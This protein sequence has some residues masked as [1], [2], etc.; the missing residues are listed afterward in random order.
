MKKILSIL[1]LILIIGCSQD[2]DFIIVEENQE[3]PQALI[4]DDLQ[5][6]KLESLNISSEVAM[7]IKLPSNGTYRIKIKHGLNNELISQE[8]IQGKE[9]DNILKVYVNSLEKS[10]YKL[11]VTKENNELIGVTAFS[12]L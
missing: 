12:K 11:E 4:I 3:V 1:A 7:N 9:G 8:K 6:I 2:E 5:G 10:S